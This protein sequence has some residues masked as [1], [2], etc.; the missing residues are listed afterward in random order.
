MK[1][2]MLWCS[3]SDQ[4]TC[5]FRLEYR[6]FFWEI[7]SL[8]AVSQHLASW[9]LQA[10]PVKMPVWQRVACFDRLFKTS[11]YHMQPS[12][13]PS[14]SPSVRCPQAA[15]IMKSCQICIQQPLLLECL[16]CISAA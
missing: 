2:N 14:M 16:A 4:L 8:G 5:K 6:S 15:V 10:D 9:R 1:L 7:N 13:N 11:L 3:F 12:A